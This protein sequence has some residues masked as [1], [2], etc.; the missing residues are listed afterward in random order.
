V[1]QALERIRHSA[2]HKKKERFTA[3]FH[4]INIDLLRK[5]FTALKRD[6]AAGVDG[7]TWKDY[8]ADLEH[9]LK[10]L[11]ARVKRRAYRALPSRRQYIPKPDGRQRPLAWRMGKVDTTVGARTLRVLSMSGEGKRA[12]ALK[13]VE[14]VVLAI[15]FAAVVT[16]AFYHAGLGVILGLLIALFILVRFFKVSWW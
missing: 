9:K 4:R 10:D 14:V 13:L 3:L 15:L 7:L 2:R 16:V 1:P 6:A 12:N 11:H 8:E 5:A